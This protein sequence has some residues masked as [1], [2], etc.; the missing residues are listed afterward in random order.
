LALVRLP[1]TLVPPLLKP[2]GRV[3]REARQERG[4][5]QG[6]IAAAAGVSRWVISRLESGKRWPEGGPDRIVEAYATEC[7]VSAL[8]LWRA[9]IK[10]AKRGE[11]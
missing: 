2:L 7:E 10:R 6:D 8:D 1:S 3:L 4:V 11:Q 5:L 9:A